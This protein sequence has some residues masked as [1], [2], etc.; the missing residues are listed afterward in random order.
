MPISG[1]K[2]CSKD[3]W[4]WIFDNLIKP[5]VEDSGLGYTCKRSTAIRGNILKDIIVDLYNSD[6]V[7]ADLTDKV[8]NV[9][10]ELGVRHGLTNKTI[11]L[12]QR[13]KDPPFDLIN[14]ASHV[15]KWKTKKGQE[16]LKRKIRELLLHIERN[17]DNPDNPVSDFLEERPV[18]RGGSRQEMMN[19][20]EY[21]D[22]DVPHIVVS[23]K[24]LSLA[25][26]IGILLYAYTEKGMTLRELTKSVATNWWRVP[27][28]TISG[29]VAQMRE[30]VIKEGKPGKY[31]YRLSGK[32]RT[33]IRRLIASLA[34][35]E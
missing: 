27:S 32:G 12:T 13:R 31:V 30:L 20:V 24:K 9:F 22:E 14:Y 17:P 2:S 34:T 8:P 18:R 25:N 1:T 5:A 6:V 23:P 10:Y 21:D 16:N 33:S 11:V 19:V 29:T 35:A 3:Q 4:Q 15:Y 28:T 7:I 26:V